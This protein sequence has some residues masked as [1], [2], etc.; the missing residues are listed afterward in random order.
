MM[1]DSE[2]SSSELHGVQTEAG[3]KLKALTQE[4]KL[5]LLR[6]QSIKRGNTL[7][8]TVDRLTQSGSLD[9]SRSSSR[10]GDGRGS[11][12]INQGGYNMDTLLAA[13]AEAAAATTAT[14]AFPVAAVAAAGEDRFQHPVDPELGEEQSDMTWASLGPE[15]EALGPYPGMRGFFPGLI[16]APTNASPSSLSAIN[17]ARTSPKKRPLM[18]SPRHA[19]LTGMRPD[20]LPSL[21]PKD[22]SR[23]GSGGGPG[24]PEDAAQLTAP[25]VVL[26]GGTLR[27][28]GS[29]S[30][31]D[32]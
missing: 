11:A 12:N 18:P 29:T 31:K 32:L 9:K 30:G 7:D 17:E 21:M 26:S 14:V 10:R 24:E 5:Q 8:A 25:S 19:S 6:G 23:I 13:A 28:R 3:Q 2:G 4:E 20:L 1:Q 15:A 27:H 16:S 22:S